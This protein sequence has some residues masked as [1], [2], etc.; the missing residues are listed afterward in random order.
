MQPITA[1]CDR[2][3]MPAAHHSGVRKLSEIW[4]ICLHDEEAPTAKSAASYFTSSA[5]GGSAHLCV[6]EKECYR[7]LANNVIPWGASSAPSLQANLHGLHIEQA[8]YARW[9]PGQWL[10]HRMTIE[11]A[12]YKTA[13]HLHKFGLPVQFV[14]AYDLARGA[15]S[16]HPVKGVTTHAEITKA[17]K[18][19]DPHHAW[20]YD[21]TDPGPWYPRRRF[22]KRVAAFYAEL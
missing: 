11:R 13:F 22:M 10:L 1:E 17:S 3:F 4:W 18:R 21:H 2:R 6:D 14:D 16:G 5:S 15:R 20:R 12:A 9:V 8:G 7:C 19:L